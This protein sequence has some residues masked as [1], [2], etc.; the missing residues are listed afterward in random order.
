MIH[1]LIHRA[2]LGTPGNHHALEAPRGTTEVLTELQLSQLS[3]LFQDFSAEPVAAASL[4][5]ATGW[6]QVEMKSL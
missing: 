6:V 5:Q 1:Q 2:T 4:G 3:E